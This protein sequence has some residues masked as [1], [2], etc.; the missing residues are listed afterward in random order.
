[1]TL[2]ETA[3]ARRTR[4]FNERIA[5][6]DAETKIRTEQKLAL[7][8]AIIE[9]SVGMRETDIRDGI[10]MALD[11]PLA[12]QGSSL[13]RMAETEALRLTRQI[14]ARLFHSDEAGLYVRLIV[15]ATEVCETIKYSY[16]NFFP[17]YEFLKDKVRELADTLDAI[18][19]EVDEKDV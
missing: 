8:D 9:R 19:Q 11:S 15:A 5:E 16:I 17:Q 4:Q 7:M 2:A 3:K 14:H 18:K 10:N 13:R 6:I 12:L 1:M